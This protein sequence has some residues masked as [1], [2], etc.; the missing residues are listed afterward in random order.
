MRIPLILF[1]LA[2]MAACAGNLPAGPPELDSPTLYTAYNIWHHDR[3]VFCINFKSGDKIIPAGTAVRNVA[4]RTI[5]DGHARVIAFRLAG[6]DDW[7]RVR[8]IARWHPGE[9]IESYRDKMFGAKDFDALT[10]GF[11]DQEIEAIRRG[12]LVEDMSKAAVLVSYGY[13]PEHATDGIDRHRWV[14]W[15]NKLH[16]KAVCFNREG[17]TVTC[18]GAKLLKTL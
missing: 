6:T 10:A 3:T 7:V 11:S 17:R 16:R 5:N 4:I 14:Y 15:Q 8:F 13:P 1:L 18:S 12:V 2:V 9:T